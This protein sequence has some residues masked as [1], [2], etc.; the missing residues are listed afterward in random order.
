MIYASIVLYNNV[1][2]ELQITINCFLDNHQ[3][4]IL[5]LIDNSSNN[6]LR[7]SFNDSR[8]IYIHNDRNIGFGAAHNIAINK[9]KQLGSKYH[10]I[11]NPDIYFEGN[12]VNEMVD[13][14]GKNCSVGMMMP[15]IL[16]SDGT[17]QFLPKLL[18]SPL[19]IL[20]RKFK[21]PN[22]FYKKFINKYELRFVLQDKIY[23]TPILSG[24]FI[25]L[26][27]D[28]IEEI[29]IFDDNYFMYFEDWDLSR[30]IHKKYKTLY[31]PLV[32]VYHGYESG[33]N[34]KIKLFK[35]FIQS[36]FT[37]FNKW[38][39]FFDNERVQMNKRTLSQFD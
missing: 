14:M 24:C 30:R 18:P 7:E 13:Y 10:F 36:A 2:S 25:L 34:K 5:F 6:L 39:W 20:I 27:L 9:S 31:Y 15:K 35:I 19:S 26:N 28:V 3:D 37:Y 23:N 38:G 22:S 1:I 29:G 17:V 32:S 12:I 8:I 4:R 11:I 33:A 21:K 16:N